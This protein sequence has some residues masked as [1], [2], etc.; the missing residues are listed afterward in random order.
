MQPTSPSV[1]PVKPIALSPKANIIEASVGLAYDVLIKPPSASKAKY[2]EV[3]CFSPKESLDERLKKAEERKMTMINGQNES[4]AEKYERVRTTQR[5]L[6]DEAE[7]QEAELGERLQRKLAQAQDK[8]DAYMTQRKE[9]CS[10]EVQ[11]VRDIVAQR[12]Q[13]ER[14]LHQRLLEKLQTASELYTAHLA[15][16]KERCARHVEKAKEI[17][18]SVKTSKQER[19]ADG[20]GDE[21]K[22]REEVQG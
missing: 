16:R 10:K 15:E 14:V 1:L 8:Y 5:L 9:Q 12:E 18:A 3:K 13:E 2:V 21:Q 7:R 19:A 6:F 17:A 20:Q 4:R 22:P 11:K